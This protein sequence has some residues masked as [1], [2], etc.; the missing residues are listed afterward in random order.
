MTKIHKSSSGSIKIVDQNPRPI[1]ENRVQDAQQRSSVSVK[2]ARVIRASST[3]GQ[4]RI[5]YVPRQG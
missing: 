3:D 1:S 4:I 5:R 2:S